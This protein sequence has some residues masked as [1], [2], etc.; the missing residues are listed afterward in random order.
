MRVVGKGEREPPRLWTSLP[1]LYLAPP[2]PRSHGRRVRKRKNERSSAEP[3]A[4][5][6]ACFSSFGNCSRPFLG[7]GVVPI[8]HCISHEG[9]RHWR[10]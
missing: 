8:I 7:G 4:C 3:V 2:C 10:G 5:P 9:A 6:A 1:T